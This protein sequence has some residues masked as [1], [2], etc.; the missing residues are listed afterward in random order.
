MP[1]HFA[2]R[3]SRARN[4]LAYRSTRQAGSSQFVLVCLLLI[5]PFGCTGLSVRE[6]VVRNAIADRKERL[7]AKNE[8]SAATGVVLA[9]FDLLKTAAGDLAK[10]ARSLE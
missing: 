1:H 5:V 9:R 4:G 2:R 10:A 6:P 7:Q 3:E 8:L